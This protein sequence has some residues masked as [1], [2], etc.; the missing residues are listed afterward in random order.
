MTTRRAI[1]RVPPAADAE[2]RGFD[3]AT[4]E[5]LEVIAGVRGEKVAPLLVSSA[6][7]PQ[8]CALK[9]NEILAVLQG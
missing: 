6:T 2:R 1:P 4:K 7:T 5:R 3:E 9:I 8:Q